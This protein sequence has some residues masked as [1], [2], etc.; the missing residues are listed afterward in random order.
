MEQNWFQKNK[1]LL[2]GWLTALSVALTPF[3]Q[4]GDP[5]QL[6][7]WASV[8][9]ASVVATLS[10]FGNAWR[11]QGMTI[12]GLVGN[13]AAVAASLLLQGSHVNPGQFILQLCIQTLIAISMTSQPDPK[14]KGY[15]QTNI[16]KQAK[17]EGKDLATKPK[18]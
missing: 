8:G 7:K 1:V 2:L 18:E 9:F 10:Y 15:E 12:M 5:G 14:S 17:E 11:G 13:G 16:I 6:V 4:Q 3:V